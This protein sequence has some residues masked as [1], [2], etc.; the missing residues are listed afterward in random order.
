MMEVLIN[1]MWNKKIIVTEHAKRRFE[2]RNIKFSKN[3]SNIVQQILIDLR[4][5]N[6]RKRELIRE[7][8]YKVTTNQGKV[9]IIVEHKNVCF[10]KTVYKTNLMYET[11]LKHLDRREIDDRYKRR[12]SKTGEN[13]R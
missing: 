2:Q 6:I 8:S 9:Y 1:E 7:N 13:Q 10:V 5:L 4:P 3:S 12:N 11:A